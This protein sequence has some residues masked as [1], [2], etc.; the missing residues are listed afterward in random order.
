MKVFSL[1]AFGLFIVGALFIRLN[2]RFL[3]WLGTIS[4]SI[5]LLHMVAIQILKLIFIDDSGQLSPLHPGIYLIMCFAV[6]IVMS[7]IVYYAVEKPAIRLGR[8]NAEFEKFSS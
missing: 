6:T 1:T 5:Y 7:A 3:V 8:Q 2:N 4:Y